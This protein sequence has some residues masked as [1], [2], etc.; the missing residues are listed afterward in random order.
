M[1][2]LPNEFN[3]YINV[4]DDTFTYSVSNYIVSLLPAESNPVKIEEI[5]NRIRSR[6]IE[7]TEYLFG[8]SGGYL[9]AMMR[10]DKFY[11]SIFGL[12]K[13]VRFATPIIV[14]SA[15]N[16]GGFFKQ[17]TNRWDEFHA[18][19]FYG[20]NINSIFMPQMAID[21]AATQNVLNL[22]GVR[23][24]KT[25]PWKDYTYSIDLIIDHEK[26][27]LTISVGQAGD[28]DNNDYLKSYSLGEL[29][30]FMRFS[31]E[32]AQGFEK[33]GEYYRIAKSLIAIL[34]KQKNIFFETYLSQR[35]SDNK[36]FKTAYCKFADPY[37]N[38]SSK[39]YGNVISVLHIFDYIRLKSYKLVNKI[40]GIH[41]L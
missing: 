26:V 33:I 17:I 37:D 16:I 19:T 32:N 24:I 9:I 21:S 5:F 15:G 10:N 27:N 41:V 4:D 8:N 30:S 31:F 2:K 7:L 1:T 38:Y 35:G 20:G 36:F 6:N 40:T 22:E 14:Q 13:C 23:E 29:N 34:T 3:G 28:K 11:H 39:K 25:R 18:I 12:D